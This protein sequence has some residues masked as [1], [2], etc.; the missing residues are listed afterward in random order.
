VKH[1]SA[2]ELGVS[3]ETAEKLATYVDLLLRWTRTI[4]LISPHDVEDVWQRHVLD[5]LQ[6]AAHI[7]NGVSHAI[8]LGSGAGLPGLVLALA[9]GRT[10]HLIEADRRKAAFLREAARKTGAPV[11]LHPIR[12]E[13]ADPPPAPLVTA[14]AVAPLPTLL[15]WAHPFLQPGGICLFLKGR[16]VED[17]LTTARAGWH[18]R[19]SRTA[20]N[21]DQAASILRISEIGRVGHN[22]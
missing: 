14:R 11:V 4:N 7:P 12:I 3:R 22:S 1:P 8:D 13:V 10:F 18:M 20:S 19:V 5:C 2:N 15:T 16:T 6:L 9:T 21:T 17:E